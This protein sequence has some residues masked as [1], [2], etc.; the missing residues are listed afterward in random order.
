MIVMAY[1]LV[2]GDY[3]VTDKKS[4]FIKGSRFF[5]MNMTSSFVYV[6]D[7]GILGSSGAYILMLFIQILYG[8]LLALQHLVTCI[9]VEEIFLYV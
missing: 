8:H 1:Y 5:M 7:C 3:N 2:T 9:V 6:L 4:C